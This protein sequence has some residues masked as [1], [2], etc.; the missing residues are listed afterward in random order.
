[1]NV[2]ALTVSRE[3]VQMQFAAGIEH[4]CLSGR[5]FRSAADVQAAWFDAIELVRT[6]HF[7][8]IDDDDAL[9]A[10]HAEVISRCIA[11]GA[12]VA[13]TDES[14]SGEH[15]QR[16]AYSQ[17]AH[18]ADPCL[19]HHLA[20]FDT[21]LAREALRTLPR[22]N[23]WPE[24]LLAWELAKRAGAA[25]IDRIGYCWNRRAEGLHR[26]WFTVLGMANSRAWCME[27]P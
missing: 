14:V 3:P 1:M 17:A 20:V 21:A 2:T 23:F 13:Y 7:F 6:P 12:G 5:I 24:M 26:Q 16:Q 22:G 25:H 4:R 10:D 19:V 11:A 9:P 15:R 18:F 27:N 8:Y